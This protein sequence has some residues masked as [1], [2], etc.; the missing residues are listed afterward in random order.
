MP[1]LKLARQPYYRWLERPVSEVEFE[2]GYR[3]NALFD[4]HRDAPD[5]GYRFSDAR[6]AQF[7]MPMHQ[8]ALARFGL[9]LVDAADLEALAQC[10]EASNRWSFMLVLA[11]P[12][13]TGTTGLV[14]NP[15]AVF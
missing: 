4:A 9:P 15:I 5:F 13:I 2:Q 7:P 3:A 12:R 14:V 8:I 10:C 1:V 11:P 6:P